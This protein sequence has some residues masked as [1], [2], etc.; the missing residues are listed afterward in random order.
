MTA[1]HFRENFI[2]VI[3]ATRLCLEQ[4][5]QMPAL[6]LLYSLM[7][8]FAWAVA[9]TKET[10]TRTRFEAWVNRWVIQYTPLPCTA[11]EL[12]AARCGVLHSLTSL[13]DLNKAGKVRHIAYAWGP[14]PLNVLEKSI[15][16]I[17][18]TDIVG[19][20]IDQLLEAVA[21]GMDRTL[22]AAEH[23]VELHTNLENAGNLHFK[24]MKTE[25]L[26]KLIHLHD[27][28]NSK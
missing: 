2:Q 3:K 5:L 6:I 11:T 28:K 9:G 25:T 24:Q 10:N 23:D 16:A 27:S 8:T 26:N 19:I 4:D 17:G 12:Y 22:A 20:H 1:A 18:R 21:S 15:E 14:A 7:D 13:A